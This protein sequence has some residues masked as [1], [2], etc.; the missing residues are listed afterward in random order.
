MS[1]PARRWAP[2][3]DATS[4]ADG[5]TSPPGDAATGGSVGRRSVPDN[6]I[7][8]TWWLLALSAATSLVLVGGGEGLQTFAV[9]SVAKRVVLPIAYVAFA[10]VTLGTRTRAGQYPVWWVALAVLLGA[11]TTMEVFFS[12]RPLDLDALTQGLAMLAGLLVIARAGLLA[13]DWTDGHTR[14]LLAVVFLFG[15]A[16]AVLDRSFNPFAALTVPTALGLLYL[17]IRERH[18]RGRHLLLALATSAGLVYW[19][20]VDTKPV[21]D[22]TLGQLALGTV[23]LLLTVLPPALRLAAVY[24]APVVV[25][26][27]AVWLGLV[28]LLTGTSTDSEEVTLSHRSYETAMVREGAEESLAAQLIGLGPGATVDLSGSPDADTLTASGRDLERVDDVHLLTTY[29]LLKFGVAGLVWLALFLAFFLRILSR[30]LRRPEPGR[31]I[32]LVFAACGLIE[33]FPAATYLFANPLPALFL[34]ILWVTGGRPVDADRPSLVH[35]PA[36][37]AVPAPS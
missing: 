12:S 8:V 22:A 34:G 19:A 33:A 2:A 20:S 10:L 35:S 25:G 24:A 37:V 5:P 6:I 32:L 9:T 4:P 18:H 3:P 31:I 17:A 29:L 27:A 11:T 21:S 14:A 36:A 7:R 23:V 16:A 26:M 28:P 1:A 30:E 15:A 13:R